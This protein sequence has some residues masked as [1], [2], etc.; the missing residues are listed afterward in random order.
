MANF[1]PV[2]VLGSN[3]ITQFQITDFYLVSDMA[4]F[5][6]HGYVS[7]QDDNGKFLAELD[8][9]LIGTS[10]SISI[11]DVDSQKTY[12][13]NAPFVITRITQ[14]VTDLSTMGGIIT[15]YFTH[16]WWLTPN[17]QNRAYSP[18]KIHQYVSKILEDRGY[19]F[20]ETPSETEDP[21]KIRYKASESDWDFLRYKILPLALWKKQPVNLWC[22]EC[23]LWHF[24][25]NFDMKKGGYLIGA[26][27]E[28]AAVPGA[29][30]TENF[31][32][33]GSAAIQLG[34]DSATY[35]AKQSFLIEDPLGGGWLNF[36]MMPVSQSVYNNPHN[37]T[38]YDAGW[39]MLSQGTS[40]KRIMNMPL[41]DA[42]AKAKHADSVL[43]YTW[44][45]GIKTLF[46]ADHY[47][48]G[49]GATLLVPKVEYGENQ[50]QTGTFSHWLSVPW[51]VLRIEHKMEPAE[52]GL[53][54]TKLILGQSAMQES[55]GRFAHDMWEDRMYHI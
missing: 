34:F 3:E 13:F 5:M 21:P 20:G 23:G 36:S 40:F 35:D 44:G 25:T 41:E 9:L 19:A 17:Y 14:Q 37:H 39:I 12:P 7:F 31:A 54:T 46:T 30:S 26:I 4:E 1:Y 38:I 28:Q 11:E 49:S 43:T 48:C 45:I 27:G 16:K 8:G 18:L 29:G 51:T 15:V 32:P 52:K 50:K 10:I 2:V 33:R 47:T 55:G 24:L 53:I 42:L 22:D 6:P